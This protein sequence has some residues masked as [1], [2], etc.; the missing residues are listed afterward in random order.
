MSTTQHTRNS[1]HAPR[2]QSSLTTN[3]S[4]G[5]RMCWESSC[6]R[7]ATAQADELV[8]KHPPGPTR[9]KHSELSS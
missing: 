4:I 2:Q 3:R 6:S 5:Q 9:V 7:T 1:L 8:V